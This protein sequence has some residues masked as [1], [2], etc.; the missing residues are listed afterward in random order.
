MIKI[1]FL[2]VSDREKKAGSRGDEQNLCKSQV[3]SVANGIV[4][5]AALESNLDNVSSDNNANYVPTVGRWGNE[6][7]S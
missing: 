5:S 6:W 3:L 1:L 2:N 7:P 4:I